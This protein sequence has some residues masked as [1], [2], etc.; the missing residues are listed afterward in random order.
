[1]LINI[2]I[3]CA[4][5][6]T[7]VTYF[8][9][10]CNNGDT[11]EQMKKLQEAEAEKREV[12]ETASADAADTQTGTYRAYIAVDSVTLWNRAGRLVG[13]SADCCSHWL[14]SQSDMSVDKSGG[15]ERPEDIE[16]P[17]RTHFGNFT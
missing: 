16:S 5:C 1:M 15:K 2:G 17:E 10:W 3:C 14:V 6:E 4:S 8:N 12:A 7:L 11:A 13:G 9:L